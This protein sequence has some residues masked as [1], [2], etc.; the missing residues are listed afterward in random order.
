VAVVGAVAACRDALARALPEVHFLDLQPGD[1]IDAIARQLT[2]LGHLDHLVWIAASEPL[3]S[4][5]DDR[6]IDDQERGVLLAFRTVQALI[7]LGYGARDLG[8]SVI[9]LRAQPIDRHDAV[10]PTH[11]SLHGLI[12]CMAKEYAHWQ[13]RLIDVE[14]WADCAWD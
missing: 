3:P 6:I 13:V 4:L 2:A 12:G 8:W 7:A 9:T 10:N 14:S 5:T 11:A 1:T